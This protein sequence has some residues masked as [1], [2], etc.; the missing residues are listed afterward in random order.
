MG[1]F[2]QRQSGMGLGFENTIYN[3]TSNLKPMTLSSWQVVAKA[4]GIE[5]VKI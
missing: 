4:P 1:Q 2:T 5:T 3:Q